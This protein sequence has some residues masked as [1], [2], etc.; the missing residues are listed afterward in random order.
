MDKT[1]FGATTPGWSGTES[2]DNEG[3]LHIPKVPAL[4]E[5]HHQIV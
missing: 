4:L 1:L 3:V 2:E 5:T